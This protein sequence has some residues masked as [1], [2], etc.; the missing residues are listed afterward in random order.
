MAS[1]ARLEEEEQYFFEATFKHSEA[2]GEY[3]QATKTEEEEG[4][5]RNHRR[6][7]RFPVWTNTLSPVPDDDDDA[8]IAV[9]SNFQPRLF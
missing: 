5:T 7:R 2:S 6:A 1:S 9:Y 3:V 8:H 4:F